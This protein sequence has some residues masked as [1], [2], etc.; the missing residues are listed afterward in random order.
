MNK[1]TENEKLCIAS[2]VQIMYT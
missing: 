1:R 2:V